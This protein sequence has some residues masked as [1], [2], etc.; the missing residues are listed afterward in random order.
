M[1]RK[2]QCNERCLS[3]RRPKCTCACGGVNHGSGGL[4]VEGGHDHPAVLKK[5]GPAP[6]AQ[7][8]AAQLTLFDYFGSKGGR[9]DG[10]HNAGQETP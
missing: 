9:L 3:A 4:L 8:N 5:A 1:A 7:K 2:R 10:T 6:R